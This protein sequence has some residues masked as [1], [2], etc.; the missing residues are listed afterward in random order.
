MC[1]AG[2]AARVSDE[3]RWGVASSDTCF[4]RLERHWV[5][6]GGRGGEAGRGKGREER[7]SREEKVV[8][9]RQCLGQNQ[10][11]EVRAGVKDY[12]D[13]KVSFCLTGA[14]G[15]LND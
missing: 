2:E 1:S 14:R 9:R 4:S 3:G 15:C 13:Q 12:G 11:L 5:G 6:K 8:W 7:G 10:G